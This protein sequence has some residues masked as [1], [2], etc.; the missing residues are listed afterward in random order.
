MYKRRHKC[1]NILLKNLCWVVCK[2]TNVV[3]IIFNKFS[4]TYIIF[5]SPNIYNLEVKLGTNNTCCKTLI[6]LQE[7][8]I[9]FT[10]T[11]N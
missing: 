6:M 4:I 11:P 7:L 1:G 10:I 2:S 8:Y 3:Y 9:A 5:I